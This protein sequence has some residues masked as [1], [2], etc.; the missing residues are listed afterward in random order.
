MSFTPTKKHE[1]HASETKSNIPVQ[2][3]HSTIRHCAT[4]QPDGKTKML[5]ILFL[6]LSNPIPANLPDDKPTIFHHPVTILCNNTFRI[7]PVFARKNSSQF[8]T[9]G[10]TTTFNRHAF[11]YASN[12]STVWCHEFSKAPD[13]S[14]VVSSLTGGEDT[15]AV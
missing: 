2:P 11:S 6:F 1:E 7:M 15:Q 3:F 10:E 5:H 14:S 8:Y 9:A 4:V 13:Y 12:I